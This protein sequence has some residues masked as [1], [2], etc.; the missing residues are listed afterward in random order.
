[1][2]CF[3]FVIC[4]NK[5]MNKQTLNIDMDGVVADW[6]A[7]AMK[8][9]G[10]DSLMQNGRWPDKDWAR[11]KACK[12]FYRDL[13]KMPK[14]DELMN[15]ARRFRDELGWN[16]NMLTAIP[17][18]NDVPECFQDKIEWQQEFFPDVRV[19]FGPYSQDK[20]SHC[21]PG[22]V[23]IDD[24]TDNCEDWR[25]VGGIAIQVTENYDLALKQLEE[26]FIKCSGRSA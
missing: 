5:S 17:H 3:F 24:R 15:L 10:T 1:M 21:R 22:D 4:Y 6:N 2:V 14:A 18:H 26:L 19:H 8:I 20:K 23:L 25:S 13:P 16:I 9:L 11:L 12:T 7:Y